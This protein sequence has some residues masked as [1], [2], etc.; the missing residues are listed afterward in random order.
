MRPPGPSRNSTIEA[1]GPR[2]STMRGDP[3]MDREHLRLDSLRSGL[4]TPV[5][6]EVGHRFLLTGCRLWLRVSRVAISA[7]LREV[8]AELVQASDDLAAAFREQFDQLPGH[9]GDLGGALAHRDR[10]RRRGVRPALREG[11]PGR[12]SLQCARGGRGE[13]RGART[14]CRRYLSPRSPLGR[15]CGAGDQPARDV[16]WRKAAATSPVV[17]IACPA[18]PRL[19]M[20]AWLSR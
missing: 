7:A 3:G 2:A 9:A 17:A 14:I 8:S 10:R 16:L 19:V 12:R 5:L 1:V 4:S 15:E 20:A 6:M 18:A 13:R 11:P